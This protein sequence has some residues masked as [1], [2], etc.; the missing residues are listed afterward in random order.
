MTNNSIAKKSKIHVP[1][2]R[3][4]RVWL[5]IAAVLLLLSPSDAKAQ[6]PVT[7][8]TAVATAYQVYSGLVKWTDSSVEKAIQAVIAEVYN[9]RDEELIGRTEGLLWAFS[10]IHPG[11]KTPSDLSNLFTES[12]QLKGTFEYIMTR[13][14]LASA[15]AV[16]PAYNLLVPMM[17]RLMV[18]RKD[19]AQAIQS[20]FSGAMATN[21]T[22]AG[23]AGVSIF[24]PEGMLWRN[25][26][27]AHRLWDYHWKRI[28]ESTRAIFD[29]KDVARWADSYYNADPVAASVKSAMMQLFV[30]GFHWAKESKVLVSVPR[31]GEIW[32]EG[33]VSR[34]AFVLVP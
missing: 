26:I 25:T 23:A 30:F 13:G 11:Q 21:Y 16:T 19:S 15:H 7:L 33:K 28:P 6:E 10:V 17:G 27:R 34:D 8:S 18:L 1:R 9:S 29:Y 12:A 3:L 14:N 31:I 32:V 24:A 20:L 5:L 22:Y 2:P 4:V